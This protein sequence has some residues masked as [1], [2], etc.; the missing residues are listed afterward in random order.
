MKY[1][2]LK[3]LF[4]AFLFIGQSAYAIEPLSIKYVDPKA[5]EKAQVAFERA[6]VYVKQGNYTK[7]LEYLKTSYEYEPAD[8]TAFGIGFAYKELKDYNNAIKWYKKSFE[9]G[10]IDGGV[11]LGLLYKK[12][13]KDYPNAIKWYK[14]AIKKGDIDARKNLGLLY[15][16]QKDKLNSATYMIGMIGH[17]YTKE[18]VLGLLRDDWKIDEP[19]LKKAYELQ[20]TLVP[21][22]YTG[23]IE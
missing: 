19:T 18:R 2:L 6:T 21:N 17:P 4:L 14:K 8:G 3:L 22:P 9:M 20:K 16:Q 10:R 15:H 13:Y 1:K 5:S 23:G 7:A 11:N 12:V